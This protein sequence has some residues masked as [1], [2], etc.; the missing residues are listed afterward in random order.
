V[1]AECP[2]IR[3]AHTD[4]SPP[5]GVRVGEKPRRFV[6]RFHYELL[7]CGVSGHELVG[8][9]VREVRPEDALVLREHDGARWQRCLR[10]DSWL[11]LAPPSAPTR[12]HLP[13]LAE[14]EL[15]LRGKPLRDKIVL[16]AIAVDR[17]L[18]F[19]VLG[20]LA[21]AVFLFAAHQH[22]LHDRFYRVLDDLQ[23]ALGGGQGSGRK[24][25]ILHAID[26]LFTLQTSKL[27]LAGAGIAAYALLEGAEAVGLWLQRRWAEYL[28]FVATTALLPLE[29]YELTRT[30]SPFK[31]IALIVNLAIV[32]YLLYAK[33]LFG[34]R[35]GAAAE[36]AERERDVGL[37][38]LERAMP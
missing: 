3:P 9:D 11:P 1:A 19:V 29:V 32:V 16:R 20:L 28:T 12:D 25:G 8:L 26:E 36:H 17:A 10:C 33:R 15:P 7:V 23:T 31:V 13:P 2:A 24:H 38:A 21:V 14:I 4:S 35:G 37:Q 34:L 18:H 5:P 27:R 6:P 22:D 30:V